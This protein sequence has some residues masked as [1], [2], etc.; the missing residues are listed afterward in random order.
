MN[1]LLINHVKSRRCNQIWIFYKTCSSFQC[2]WQKKKEGQ[3]CSKRFGKIDE[4]FHI[5]QEQKQPKI[6]IKSFRNIT[7]PDSQS[8]GKMQHPLKFTLVMS[9]GMDNGQWVALII[10]VS[11]NCHF[12]ALPLSGQT[13]N[14]LTILAPFVSCVKWQDEFQ[15]FCLGFQVLGWLIL[16]YRL[17]RFLCAICFD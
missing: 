13:V 10:H 2:F 16:R 5:K 15:V 11:I 9:R 3:R 7:Q 6:N 1:N 4:V 17:G 12:V 8:V 14:T